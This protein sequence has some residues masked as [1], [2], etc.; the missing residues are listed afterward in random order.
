MDIP[1]RIALGMPKMTNRSL[2]IHHVNSRPP[3]IHSWGFI[4]ME[5]LPW[6]QRTLSHSGK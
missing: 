2:K 4:S 5:R 1:V 3:K 6:D